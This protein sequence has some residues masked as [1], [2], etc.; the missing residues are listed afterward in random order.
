MFFTHFRNEPLVDFSQEANQAKARA[1]IDAAMAAFGREYPALIGEQRVTTPRMIASICPARPDWT[2]G[3]VASCG[4]EHVGQAVR[5]AEDAF[6]DWAFTE[7]ERRAE[8]LLRLAGLIRRDRFEFLALLGLE[9]GKDWFEAE[10]EIGEA[11]DFCD[12]Y[13]RL[14]V[15]HFRFQPLSR[16][17]G[18]EN[19][20]S[21]IPLGVGAVISP[22]NFP[23]AI[24]VGMTAAAVVSGNT[25][26]VKPSSDTPVIACK[27]MD[28]ILEAGFPPGVVNLVPG[29]GGELGDCLVSHPKVRF[30]TFT[31]SAE[32]GLR[33]HG[34]AGS[35]RKRWLT[36]LVAEM[37]GKNAIIVDASA[38]LDEAVRGVIR[39]AY[40][41]QGQKCSACSRLLLHEAVHD[42]F[43]EILVER[44]KELPAGDPWSDPCVFTGPVANRAA[45]DKILRFIE[46][47]RRES[48]L[49]AGG[50]AIDRP[51][52]FI[53]PTLFGGVKPGSALA[54]EEIFGPVL[55]AIR[56]HS[57][58][59][60][61]QVA[62][63]TDY[64]L[65]GAVFAR[66]PALLDQARRRFH[67]GN[68]YLNRGCTGAMVGVHPFGGF[69][70]SG[71]DSKAGGPDYLLNFTQGK[72]VAERVQYV[73]T[74]GI[75]L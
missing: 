3:R 33:I 22:W 45:F 61:L 10:A 65:T 47:G 71:T 54:L 44:M 29:P 56:V 53:A 18:E 63:E 1:A 34:L 59:E 26:V 2:V 12:Y 41:F 9:I 66:D 30:V 31:G 49:L 5:A 62:N 4:P 51:G 39:S 27:L 16:M 37:G 28:L 23:L 15:H 70:L 69:N 75:G 20:Y 48:T 58:A 46:A 36:R 17:P 64:G 32:V 72:T 35:T 21:Y 11:I 55:A 68:L 19:T 40:G 50:A 43:L 24:L 14:A 13:A 60:A 74:P 8:P 42:R 73:R 67:C 6:Q 38:D 25:V 57:F 7:V 52:H